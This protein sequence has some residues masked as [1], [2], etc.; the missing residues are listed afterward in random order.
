MDSREV[1]K[2]LRADGWRLKSQVGSHMQL[3][4][5]VK[6]GKVTVP[7]PRKDIKLKTLQN[8]ERQSGLN[9]RRPK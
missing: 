5:A 1:L 8:I 9:L 3:D 6:K 2:L 7:H 4:H